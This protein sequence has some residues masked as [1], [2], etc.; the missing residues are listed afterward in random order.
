MNNTNETTDNKGRLPYYVKI[1]FISAK[2][3]YSFISKNYQ[4]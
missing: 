2:T 3:L 1:V 4:S